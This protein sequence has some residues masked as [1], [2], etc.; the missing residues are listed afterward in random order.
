M[1]QKKKKK[2]QSLFLKGHAFST[3]LCFLWFNFIRR[4]EKSLKKAIVDKNFLS[5]KEGA[6]FRNLK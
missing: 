3:P 1:V 2:T 5:V 4:K 6:V